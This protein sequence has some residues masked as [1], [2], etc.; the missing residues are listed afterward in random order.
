PRGPAG[1]A[2]G[3]LCLLLGGLVEGR[4][5][6]D[7]LLPGAQL[8]G[9]LRLAVGVVPQERLE[10]ARLTP[11]EPRLARPGTRRPPPGAGPLPTCPSRS[12]ACR[13]L[14]PGV[15]PQAAS[16]SPPPIH[17]PRHRHGMP[18]SERRGWGIVWTELFQILLSGP[19][20]SGRVYVPVALR[21]PWRGASRA[22][23]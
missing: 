19:L 1:E 18:S 17:R 6:D 22:V 15:P 7:G 14:V 23:R 16:Q 8:D 4:P 2:V 20:Q 3:T 11:H 9:L 13:A 5:I 10:R 21:Q 12:R